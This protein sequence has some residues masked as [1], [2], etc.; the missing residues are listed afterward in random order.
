ME[1]KE[2]KGRSRGLLL[3]DGMGRERKGRREEGR[4]GRRKVG[5]VPGP[6]MKNASASLA[7]KHQFGCPV[8]YYRRHGHVE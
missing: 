5:E 4:R 6:S 7:N 3:K 2:R 8:K 1:W